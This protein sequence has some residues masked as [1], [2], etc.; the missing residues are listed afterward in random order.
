MRR[1]KNTRIV[2]KQPRKPSQEDVSAEYLKTISAKGP[3][4]WEALKK[5]GQEMDG[6]S[7]DKL[8]EALMEL[9][10]LNKMSDRKLPLY[11]NHEWHHPYTAKLYKERLANAEV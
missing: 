1:G 6:R 2:Y 9:N 8:Q 10:M 5:M 11:I 4:Y 7:A 3:A